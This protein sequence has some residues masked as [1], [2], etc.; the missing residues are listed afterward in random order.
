MKQAD[1]RQEPTKPQ[2]ELSNDTSQPH[3]VNDIP[4]QDRDLPFTADPAKLEQPRAGKTPSST[5]SSG[6]EVSID[7]SDKGS[8][9]PENRRR[10]GE[11][12]VRGGEAHRFKPGQSG[13]PGG[14]PKIGALTRAFRALLEQ[15]VPGDRQGR[16]H[17][18]A[19]AERTVGLAMRGHLGAVR[20]VGDRA[21]GRSVP[22]IQLTDVVVEDE[23]PDPSRADSN[24]E[25]SS[26]AVQEAKTPNDEKM[27]S[28]QKR[29]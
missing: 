29:N 26:E 20:E 2:S 12:A 5:N 1:E 13:N 7:Q 8:P 21:E 16:T 3:S 25:T 19:I 23:T 18:Q 24:V 11:G 17:A 28:G 22:C 27:A 15:P 9:A 10:T 14:R 4:S 6:T